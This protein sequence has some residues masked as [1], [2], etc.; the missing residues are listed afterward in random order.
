MTELQSSR[1]NNTPNHEQTELTSNRV[2]HKSNRT[3][4]DCLGNSGNMINIFRTSAKTSMT[5]VV[6]TVTLF[7]DQSGIMDRRERNH[8]GEV[9]QIEH[10]LF[11]SR[12]SSDV[13]VI[14]RTKYTGFN[15]GNAIGPIGLPEWK[16]PGTMSATF[17]DKKT[18]FGAHRSPVGGSTRDGVAEQ[19]DKG[20]A[21]ERK[22]TDME[23]VFYHSMSREFHED[24]ILCGNYKAVINLTPGG[25]MCAAACI[26]ARVVNMNFTISDMHGELVYKHLLKMTFKFMSTEGMWLYDPVFAQMV[27]HR[28]SEETPSAGAAAGQPEVTPKGKNR[29]GDG[30]GG[31][32]GGGGS[33]GAA[34]ESILDKL[35]TL[36][37]KKGAGASAAGVADA[38][39][40][41][42]EGEEEE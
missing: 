7:Y 34:G 6:R 24:D 41:G 42:E 3:N 14:A 19:D 22:D 10:Q 15:N 29:N 37:A 25:G 31:G 23:P 36:M 33:G 27:K 20:K 8:G 5:R 26:V 21:P 11:I 30:A 18:M 13:K 9:N 1:I 4:N 17:K 35:K 39:A 38:A 16:S 12:Q 28:V 2:S 32:S 40:D